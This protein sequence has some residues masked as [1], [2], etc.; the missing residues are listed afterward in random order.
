MASKKEKRIHLNIFLLKEKDTDTADKSWISDEF[1]AKPIVSGKPR[2]IKFDSYQLGQGEFGVVY[3]R[4]PYSKSK[5]EW[6]DFVSRELDDP[7]SLDKL[8]NKS[9]SAI[10]LKKI[11]GR[12]FV[13]AFGHGRHMID[14]AVVEYRFGLRVALNSIARNKIASI[15]KQT[16]DSSPRIS[17]TQ[18]IKASEISDYGIDAEQD[19][20]RAI[21][22]LSEKSHSEVLGEVIAGMDSLKISVTTDVRSIDAILSYALKRF[23]SSD[24]LENQ[25]GRESSFAWVDNLE[26]ISDKSLVSQLDKELVERIKGDDLS[27]IWMAIPEVIDWEDVG[28]FSYS[29]PKEGD[30]DFDEFLDIAAFARSLRKSASVQTL[31]ARHVYMISSSGRP[32]RQYSAYRSIYSEIRNSIGT[33]ILN[34]G[35][36]FK[37]DS[38]L[39]QRVNKFFKDIVSKSTRPNPPF[40]DYDHVDEEA[41]NIA[42]SKNDSKYICLDRKLIKF[43]GGHSKIELCDILWKSPGKERSRLIHVKRGRSSASLSHLFAQG[44]VSSELLVGEPKFVSEVDAQLK[45]KGAP[46]LGGLIKG[47]NYDLIYAV[48]DGASGTSLDI[49]FF[50]KVNLESSAKRL[51]KYGFNVQL[52]H[53]TE[54]AGTIALKAAKKKAKKI[55]AAGKKPT[56]KVVKISSKKA[57]KKNAKKVVKSSAKSGSKGSA[58]KK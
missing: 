22:G 4:K 46:K 38:G 49:P 58:K 27:S 51:Q 26:P 36:W 18:A 3:V 33:F 43:G 2:L 42:V 54:S 52:M 47:S 41:Y 55:A 9:Y 53:I 5:P 48:I 44:L 40:V 56:K 1:L 19:M 50:S 12:Q 21:V 39:E 35:N 16:F 24:Y 23:S 29:P 11:E 6:V 17:R 30:D 14:S 13:V 34:A 7:T 10:L 57:G 45:A 37:V 15:D 31:K 32:A 28:G 25:D 8:I 20:L